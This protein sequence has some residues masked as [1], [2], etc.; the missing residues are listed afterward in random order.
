MFR[1][2]EIPFTT[3][4][5]EANARKQRIPNTTGQDI[6]KGNKAVVRSKGI[7]GG[8]CSSSS[9]IGEGD[10]VADDLYKDSSQCKRGSNIVDTSPTE[11]SHTIWI[12]P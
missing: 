3:F 8:R 5:Q 10:L 4:F 6:G 9:A 7:H 11:S 1:F 2:G 12:Y